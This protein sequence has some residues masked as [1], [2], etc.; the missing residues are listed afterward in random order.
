MVIP[1][2]RGNVTCDYRIFL[3]VIFLSSAHF[4]YCFLWTFLLMLLENAFTRSLV[5][6]SFGSTG[7]GFFDHC[8]F[9]SCFNSH[10]CRVL[11]I[12]TWITH[13]YYIHFSRVVINMHVT[14]TN[15]QFTATTDPTLFW[16]IASGLMNPVPFPRFKSFRD[17]ST[18]TL[19]VLHLVFFC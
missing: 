1:L 18:S 8:G 19:D 9:C 2:T 4:F 7:V 16:P 5:A 11:W 6:N 13:G 10:P 17:T 14:S 15:S 3:D 12:I